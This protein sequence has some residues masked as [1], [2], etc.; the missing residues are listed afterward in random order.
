LSNSVIDSQYRILRG[1]QQEVKKMISKELMDYV[2]DGDFHIKIDDVKYST[3]L[4]EIITV[5]YML[6]NPVE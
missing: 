1:Y 5:G 3:N 4:R 6:A 2:A